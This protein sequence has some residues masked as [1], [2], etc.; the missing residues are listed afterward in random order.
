MRI[1][2]SIFFTIFLFQ[3]QIDAQTYQCDSWQTVKANKKGT[4]TAL[5]YALEPV[6]YNDVNGDMLG[7]EYE[8]MEGFKLFLKNKYDINLAINW[9]DL[10]EFEQI[11]NT[12]SSSTQKGLFGLSFFSITNERKKQVKFSPFYLPDMNVIVT[13]NKLP[14]FETSHD[15]AQSIKGLTAFTMQNTTMNDDVLNIKNKYSPDLKIVYE[16]NDYDVLREIS[17]NGNAFGYIPVTVYVVALQKGIK[18]K[19]QKILTSKREGFAAIYSKNSDWDD[20]VN[21]YFKSVECKKLISSLIK[22]YFG[23]EFSNIILDVSV[24]DTI[25]G[26][27]GDSELLTKERELVT[28]RLVETALQVE[29]ERNLRSL[30]IA[31]IGFS[32]I[33]IFLIYRRFVANANSNRKLKLQYE[34][35]IKQKDE[36]EKMNKLLKLKNIQMSLS[37]HFLFNSLNAIQY[38]VA[39]NE[40]KPTL[41]YIATF[42]KFLRQQ[43]QSGKMITQS[44]LKE[45][46][47]LQNYLLLEKNRFANKFTFM[48][49]M[50]KNVNMLEKQVP[51]SLILSIVEF[52]LYKSVL[53]R[54]DNE[55]FI[56]IMF[57]LNELGVNTIIKD[58]GISTPIANFLNNDLITNDAEILLIK[59]RLLL[60]NTIQNEKSIEI[61]CNV[62]DEIVRTEIKLPEL[63]I[64]ND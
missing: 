33:A 38:F 10:P 32:I 27:K 22:K 55:G 31:T 19:R 2:I 7:V 6:I 58:N 23:E 17:L 64:A 54:N 11:Y 57:C 63:E 39:M 61:I 49:E 37:P 50:P 42:A 46:E 16:L 30:I 43:L 59:E 13:N 36:I 4:I 26:I 15:F 12:V 56:H 9:V 51:T 60:L 44:L 47:I 41:A 45:I 20:P 40:V 52:I 24:A 62:F 48:V 29:K 1:A 35:I 25:A 18:V 3:Y 28:K 5:W 14:L 53:A 34:T 8:L 21:E